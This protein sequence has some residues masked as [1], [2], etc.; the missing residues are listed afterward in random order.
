[1]LTTLRYFLQGTFVVLAV[2]I[3]TILS[4][5]LIFVLAV[6]KL[7]A[8]KGPARNTVTHWLSSVGE[9]WISFNKLMAWLLHDMKWEVHLPDDLNHEGRYLVFCNHQSWVDIL[10]LQHCLNR[11]APFMRFLLKQELIWVPFLGFCWWALDMAFLRRHSKAQLLKNPQ[12]RGKDLENAARACEKLKHIPVSMMAFP[13]GTRFTE[14]KHKQQNS[15]FRHLLRPR[16]GGIG[17]VLY[18]LMMRLTA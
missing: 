4:T 6:V 18:S 14:A 10:V 5:L 12:L 16:Y 3:N 11:R 8:P 17:Q 15:P 9:Y 2:S 7:I 13:E 1:M